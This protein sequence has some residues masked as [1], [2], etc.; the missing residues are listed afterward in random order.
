MNEAL[1]VDE[2]FVVGSKTGGRGEP[3]IFCVHCGR[4]SLVV[5]SVG[6]SEVLS[7]LKYKLSGG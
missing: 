4:G 6:Q 3:S 2:I 7:W 1:Y 5:S